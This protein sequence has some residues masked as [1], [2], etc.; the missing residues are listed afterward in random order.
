MTRSLVLSVLAISWVP[1]ACGG[2]NVAVADNG[3]PD[4][5][6]DAAIAMDGATP[7]DTGIG[8]DSTLAGD[9]SGCSGQAPA[10]Y[11]NNLQACCQIDP[12]PPAICQ[13][14]T[15]MCGVDAP[16]PGCTSCVQPHDASDV[17]DSQETDVADAQETDVA[18]A[19]AGTSDCVP[20]CAGPSNTGPGEVCVGVLGVGGGQGFPPVPDDAGNCPPGTVHYAGYCVTSAP[21]GMCMPWP[22]ACAQDQ[23]DCMCAQ[24]ACAGSSMGCGAT[25][26]GEV[27]CVFVAP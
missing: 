12:G 16:A 24:S 22:A 27:Q 9:S 17:P 11:G 18:D 14:G 4:G 13:G 3:S 21:K 6:G 15:W 20:P 7:L 1:T 25:A 10:C 2:S 19:Q 5:G 26:P 8:G 23:L